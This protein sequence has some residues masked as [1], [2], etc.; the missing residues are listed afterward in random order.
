VVGLLVSIVMSEWQKIII[1]GK[2][3]FKKGGG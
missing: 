1:N 3:M 2:R